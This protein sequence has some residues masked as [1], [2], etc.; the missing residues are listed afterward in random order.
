MR[1]RKIILATSEVGAAGSQE[2]S[3]RTG[4]GAIEQLRVINGSSLDEGRGL[5]KKRNGHV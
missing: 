5:E 3:Q 1:L 4:Y 2:K